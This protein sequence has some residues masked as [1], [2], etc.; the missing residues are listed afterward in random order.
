[1]KFTLPRTIVLCALLGAGC[2]PLPVDGPN[3]RHIDRGA[4][5]AVLQDHREVALDYVLV[6]ISQPVL[7]ATVH[8][9]P[10]S[11]FTTFGLGR[12]SAPEQRIG[13]GDVVAVS[14]FESSAGGLF[15]PG[16]VGTRPAGFVQLPAQTVDDRGN[17][18]I[19]FAG[20]VRALGR[21]VSQLRR[22][23]EARLDK[24][25]IEP[26]IVISVTEQS[27][28]EVAVFGDAVSSSVKQQL[29]PGGER[30]LDVVARAGI[31]FPGH[32][33]FVTLQRGDRR[34]TVFFP[35][36]IESPDE[37]IFVKSGDV[38]YL[39]REPQTYVAVGALGN[40]NQTQ[41][42][43]GKFLFDSPRLSLAEAVAKAGGLL[44]T[45]ANPAQV[46][47]YRLELRSV[48]EQIGFNLSHFAP[49]QKFIPTIY[50]ANYRDPSSFFVTDQF[51]MRHKDIIYVANADSVEVDKF[52][53]FVRLITGTVA[54]VSTDVLVTRDAI[55]ALGD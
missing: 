40:V 17:I 28:N 19:P 25:A 2:A 38:L 6:D 9:D 12:G 37:N 1:M 43:T 48:L 35:R 33:V 15:S 27:S 53:S 30:V 23:I 7:E 22:D 55:R 49:D 44:D 13:V 18:R 3:Y 11:F 46:F 4:S 10:G 47:L 52:L 16:E 36:L 51:Q 54:G 21:T 24:R 34:A 39:Y 29:K 8:L 32:E 50:R 20:E 14:I 5:E 45:R 41:E 42:L 31:R 26:Q